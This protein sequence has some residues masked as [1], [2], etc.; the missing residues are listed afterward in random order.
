MQQV[1][2]LYPAALASITSAG[3]RAGG[4]NICLGMDDLCY[5]CHEDWQT[6]TMGANGFLS[7][8]IPG[9]DFVPLDTQV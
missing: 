4:E 6:M 3:W 7:T 2:L 9:N 5:E 1:N 8:A